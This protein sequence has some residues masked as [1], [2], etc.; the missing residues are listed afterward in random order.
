M[1]TNVQTL[2]DLRTAG[3]VPERDQ[4]FVDSLLQAD[5]RRGLSLKQAEWVDKI[6]TRITNW[7][8]IPPTRRSTSWLTAAST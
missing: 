4:S 1:T 8:L 7:S 6:V 3:R 5:A 2:R